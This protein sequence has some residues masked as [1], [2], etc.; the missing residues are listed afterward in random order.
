M[1]TLVSAGFFFYGVIQCNNAGGNYGGMDMSE[2]CC[3][4]ANA[5]LAVATAALGF[6]L[7]IEAMKGVVVGIAMDATAAAQPASGALCDLLTD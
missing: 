4:V 5:G 6:K 3:H 7:G 2:L 1:S